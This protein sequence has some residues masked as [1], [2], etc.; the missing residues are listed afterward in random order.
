VLPEAAATITPEA[1]IVSNPGPTATPELQT[2]TPTVPPTPTPEPIQ[3]GNLLV[4]FED[5]FDQSWRSE[6]D[7]S[8]GRLSVVNGRLTSAADAPFVLWLGDEQLTDYT[9]EFDYQ[10]GW[11]IDLYVGPYFRWVDRFGNTTNGFSPRQWQERQPNTNQW[12]KRSTD[13]FNMGSGRFKLVVSGDTYTL[14]VNNGEKIVYTLSGINP[15][16]PFGIG[17]QQDTFIDNFKLTVP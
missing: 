4:P 9:V 7:A 1:L 5:A 3:V 16:G 12:S 14:S 10:A 11:G 15:K 17:M 6:W 13:F 8:G 2:P